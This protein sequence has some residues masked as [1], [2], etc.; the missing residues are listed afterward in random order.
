M[1]TSP[2]RRRSATGIL[3]ALLLAFGPLVV[4]SGAHAE[5]ARSDGPESSFIV[6]LRPQERTSVQARSLVA[7]TA[8]EVSV[9]PVHVYTHALDGFSAQMTAEQ[10][11]ELAA[12]PSVEAVVPD[13]RVRAQG[14]C[15]KQ[16]TGPCEP[17]GV[18]RI[19]GPGGGTDPDVSDLNV[20]VI[21]TGVD[22][23]HPDLNVVGGAACSSSESHD[24]AN[25][26]GTHVAGALAGTGAEGVTGVAPG[27]RIW[28]V[29]VL[30]A[31]GIGSWANV[32]C[33]LD[34]VTGTR[35]DLD[36]DND[37]DVANL[38]L[39]DRGTDDG[40][41]GLLSKSPIHEAACAATDQGVLLVVAAG[42]SKRAVSNEIPASYDEVLTVTAVADYDGQHGAAG[43]PRCAKKLGKD[44]AA[45][46]F[47]DWAEKQDRGHTIAAPGVCIVSAWRNGGYKTISGT[48]MASP[49]VAGAAVLCI[50]AGDCPLDD[51]EATIDQLRSDAASYG[52]AYP[53]RGFKGDPAH[54]IKG[55]YYGFLVDPTAY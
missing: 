34:W 38:S 42:N 15:P 24:D 26:H 25:G 4:S 44:D 54:K 10:A 18:M 41:C 19:G 53:S 2:T 5:P 49:H 29:R 16:V 52:K 30:N 27:A 8:E 6:M 40:K 28:S 32:I 47:S 43:G 36:P 55:K 12:D 21:D 17:T 48:S 11:T 45:A 31:N 46:T 35:V 7:E 14:L 23:D 51:P 39:G 1:I 22:T 9:D 3:L 37:I 33:G 13:G 50:A 20:A